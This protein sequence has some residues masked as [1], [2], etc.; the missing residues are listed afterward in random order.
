VTCRDFIAFLWAYLSEELP[1]D[2]RREFEEHLKVCPECI[3]YVRSYE[4]TVRMASDAFTDEGDE[5]PDGVPE[6]LVLAV[7]E[8]RDS[9]V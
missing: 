4:R 5:L 6:D 8:A 2:Q 3:A 7:M 1:P 9:R